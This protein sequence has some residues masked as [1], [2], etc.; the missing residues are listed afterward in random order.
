VTPG[1]RLLYAISAKRELGWASFKKTF[2][3]LCGQ[4]LA[5]DDLQDMN[6]ARYDT[7]RGLDALGHVELDFSSTT[8]LYAAPPALALLPNSGL[9][10]AVLSGA[11][12][13]NTIELLQAHV[14]KRGDTLQLDVRNQKEESQRFPARV[15]VTA[16]TREDLLSLAK[17]TG[18]AFQEGPASWKILNFAGSLRDYLNGIEWQRTDRLNWEEQQFHPQLLRFSTT[19]SG[20]EIQLIKYIHPSRQYPLHFLWR[21]VEAAR[22]DPDWGRFAILSKARRNVIH[23]EPSASILVL[24]ATTPLPKLLA[25]ALCLCS[26]LVPRII[27]G[28]AVA[29]SPVNVPLFRFYVNV[30]PEFAQIVAGKL[31]QVLITDFRLLETEND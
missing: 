8:R 30:P 20:G 22:V 2:E 5:K 23:Y 6:F 3:L 28:S 16:E 31:D 19:P 13:P 1:D 24:P 9:P 25:R 27:S 21:G 10:E 26:G 4:H 11:R 12:S 17:A 18:I 15:A 14:Q 7:A 29:A